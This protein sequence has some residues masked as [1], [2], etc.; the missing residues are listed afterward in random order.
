[1]C[2]NALQKRVNRRCKHP[3]VQ[4]VM[5]TQHLPYRV[6]LELVGQVPLCLGVLGHDNESCMYCKHSKIMIQL[7]LV[8]IHSYHIV[9]WEP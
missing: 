1:M 2:Q 7:P 3:S 4:S 5:P 8:A 9:M 6:R